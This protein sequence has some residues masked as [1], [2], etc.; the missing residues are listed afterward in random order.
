MLS[1]AK[2]KAMYYDKNTA[3][4]QNEDAL[5][6]ALFQN[7]IQYLIKKGIYTK[8]LQKNIARLMLR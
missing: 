2:I 1:E 5:N 3:I 6:E 7:D 8:N 4:Y